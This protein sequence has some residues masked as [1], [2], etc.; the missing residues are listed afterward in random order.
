MRQAITGRVLTPEWKAKIGAAH[1]GKII[2]PEIRMKLSIERKGKHYSP[3]TEFKKGQ[4]APNKGKPNLKIRGPLNRQWKT[5]KQRSERYKF[6]RSLEYRAWRDDVFTRD[7]YTCQDCGN[8]G[9]QTGVYLNADHIK[10]WA[11]YP[12]L[13]LEVSNGQT[14]C[15]PCH[16]FKTHKDMTLM[17]RDTDLWNQDGT[18]YP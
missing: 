5:G 8:R 10:P 11:L 14:L 4:V 7:N 18:T 15:Q 9:N 6:M 2:P 17:R 12:E 3:R 13:R 1:R 16:A